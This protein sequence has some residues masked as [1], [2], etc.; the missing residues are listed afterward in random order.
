MGIGLAG[1][2]PAVEEL[3]TGRAPPDEL[4]HGAVWCA[5]DGGGGVAAVTLFGRAGQAGAQVRDDGQ[6]GAAAGCAAA[7]VP[8]A[9][10]NVPT[11]ER[12]EPAKS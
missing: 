7:E 3:V 12:D 8:S 1:H 4:G 11:A 9:S 2:A 5:D 10:N 6:G